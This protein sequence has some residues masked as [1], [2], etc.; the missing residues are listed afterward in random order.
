MHPANYS[1]LED[2]MAQNILGLDLSGL[3]FD[4]LETWPSEAKDRPSRMAVFEIG[5]S[6]FFACLMVQS[7]RKSNVPKDA[8]LLSRRIG[9]LTPLYNTVESY[10][11]A[12]D[13]RAAVAVEAAIRIADS[14]VAVISG[15]EYARGH[16][17]RAK[18]SL[19]YD[20]VERVAQERARRNVSR[21]KKMW[22]EIDHGLDLLL[23]DRE[24]PNNP[25]PDDSV[26]LQ[27][28]RLQ[29]TETDRTRD[30]DCLTLHGHQLREWIHQPQS[31]RLPEGIRMVLIGHYHLKMAVFRYGLW[32]I[33]CGCFVNIISGKHV[34]SH[35]GAPRIEIGPD[36]HC[37]QFVIDRSTGLA[38]SS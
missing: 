30:F 2:K 12:Y 22:S 31:F 34:L 16:A 19:K 21:R 37:P 17:N 1:H 10:C 18:S 4:S 15:T 3:T 32:I 33:F 11:F 9:S 8:F 38:S 5:L 24:N 23:S 13:E 20:E 29:C 27:R 35:V 28:M 6:E 14:L 26:V 25:Y 7:V 36:M